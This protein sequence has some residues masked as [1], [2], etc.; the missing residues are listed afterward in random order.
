MYYQVGGWCCGEGVLLWA[1]HI[2]VGT[3]WFITQTESDAAG[4]LRGCR[5]VVS[6]NTSK[7]KQHRQLLQQMM[8]EG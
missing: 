3:P 2:V 6:T 8:Y 7:T 5:W 4:L 1:R